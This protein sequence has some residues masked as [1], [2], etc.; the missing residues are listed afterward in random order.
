MA[1][2]WQLKPPPAGDYDALFVTSAN[3]VR[4]AGKAVKAY[5][6]LPAYAVGDA[7]ARALAGRSDV[8]VEN[9]ATGVMHRLGL[10]AD[11]LQAVNPDLL[12]VS[13]SGLGRSGPEAGA[14]VAAACARVAGRAAAAAA[15]RVTETRG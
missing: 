2:F 15:A 9:F 7:T 10:G 8:V 5:H 3:A 1:R 13:A 14:V 12:Y 6:G 4:Q 11:E